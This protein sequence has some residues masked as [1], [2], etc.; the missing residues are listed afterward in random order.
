VET[1]SHQSARVSIT[2]LSA[3]VAPIY[4]RNVLVEA[5]PCLPPL[6]S[7]YYETFRASH[8]DHC[9]CARVFMPRIMEVLADAARRHMLARVELT[10]VV[11]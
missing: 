4:L 6:A 11:E 10:H 2:S 5:D 9:F 1:R 8:D 3:Q 7:R